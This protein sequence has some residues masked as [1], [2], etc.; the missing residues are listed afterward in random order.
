MLLTVL[1]YAFGTATTLDCS[2]TLQQSWDTRIWY[3]FVIISVYAIDYIRSR[4]PFV[5]VS[6][7]NWL[8]LKIIQNI[9]TGSFHAVQR[10]GME[11]N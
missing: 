3:I 11:I 5:I 7:R 1:E 8:H 6:Q 4:A 10:N 2:I 9:F